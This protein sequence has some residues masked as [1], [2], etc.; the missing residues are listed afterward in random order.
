MGAR[1]L[2]RTST[3]DAGDKLLR[4][5]RRRSG[6]GLTWR[7]EQMVLLSTQGMDAPTRAAVTFTRP[8]GVRLCRLLRIS[9]RKNRGG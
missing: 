1:V 2:V 4:I 8:N 3:R 6:S 7:R 5:V 9:V